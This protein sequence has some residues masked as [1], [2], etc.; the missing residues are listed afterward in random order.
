MYVLITNSVVYACFRMSR[1]IPP[2]YLSGD[3]E[4]DGVY[5]AGVP[6]QELCPAIVA[7]A[8]ADDGLTDQRAF[9]LKVIGR[10]RHPVAMVNADE[11]FRKSNVFGGRTPGRKRARGDLEEDSDSDMA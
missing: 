7:D 5:P 6:W 10:P 1:V 9:L 8:E 3:E 2:Q 4:Q 11:V